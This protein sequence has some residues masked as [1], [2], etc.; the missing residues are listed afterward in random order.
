MHRQHLCGV[1]DDARFLK[2]VYAGIRNG[3]DWDALE[4]S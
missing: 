4:Q 3:A 2:S 1:D